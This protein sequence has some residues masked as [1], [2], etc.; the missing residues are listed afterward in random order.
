MWAMTIYHFS[1]I[2]V[3]Y[4]QCMYLYVYMYRLLNHKKKHEL[5]NTWHVYHW[6][7]RMNKT[8]ALVAADSLRI[9]LE[10]SVQRV[11]R[12]VYENLSLPRLRYPIKYFTT[13]PVFA[14]RV[15]NFKVAML[16]SFFSFFFFMLHINARVCMCVCVC[17]CWEKRTWWNGCIKHGNGLKCLSYSIAFQMWPNFI[18]H[19]L[20]HPYQ[21]Q[22]QKNEMLSFFLPP[23][24]Q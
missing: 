16:S 11:W 1:Q 9:T 20:S 24:K 21:Q 22:Q 2:S 10:Y 15:R 14:F 6:W 3:K 8:M 13:L 23:L 7:T 5:E 12:C 18:K 4:I 19:L 17:V